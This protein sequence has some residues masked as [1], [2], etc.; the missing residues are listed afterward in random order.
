MDYGM[1]NKPKLVQLQFANL[2]VYDAQYIEHRGSKKSEPSLI[3]HSNWS[4]KEGTVEFRH[5][6]RELFTSELAERPYVSQVV[7]FSIEANE[8]NLDANVVLRNYNISVHNII[9]L[10]FVDLKRDNDVY[11]VSFCVDAFGRDI[12][13]FFR[14]G[15]CFK[16]EVVFQE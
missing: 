14:A 10:E 9:T 5:T 2:H 8:D 7:G 6:Q 13:K 12:W 11:W 4:A 1:C 15:N 16:L 3:V